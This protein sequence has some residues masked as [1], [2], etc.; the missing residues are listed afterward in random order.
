MNVTSGSSECGL[1][2]LA[3]PPDPLTRLLMDA[4]GVT[5]AVL[6]ALMQKV[7]DALANRQ[8]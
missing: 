6:D 3:S 4:D 1:L 8:T 5:E 2:R 7:A